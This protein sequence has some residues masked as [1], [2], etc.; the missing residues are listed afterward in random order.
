[1][2]VSV[3]GTGHV[4]PVTAACLAHA[5]HDVTGMDDDADKIAT[6]SR[7]EMPSFEPGLDELVRAA[8]S[9]GRLILDGRNALDPVALLAEGFEYLGMGR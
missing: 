6:T 3:I 9:S 5:G 1:M 2:R 4:G 7:G 8:Q